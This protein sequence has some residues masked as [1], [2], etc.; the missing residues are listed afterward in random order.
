MDEVY[1][2]RTHEIEDDHWWYR[3]RRRVIEV[4]LRGLGLPPGVAILDAGCGSGRNMV[5]LAAFGSVTGLELADAS[6]A[7]ARGRGVGEVVQGTLEDMPFENARFDLAVSFDVIEHLDDDRRALGE[8]RRVVRPGGL[9]VVTVPAYQWL[10]S[11]H[12]VVN[13]HRRRYTRRTLEAAASAAGWETVS[14]THFNGLLLPAAVGHRALLRVRHRGDH[15]APP[16][17]DLE[18]TSPRLNRLLE[19]PLNLEARLIAAGRRIPCGLSL[20]AVFR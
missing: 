11:E 9:L 2:R 13:H 20:M 17:S 5:D 6:V 12:D 1:E 10:W 15:D 19:Q 18:R 3:G 7:R 8:L 4:A 16:V 14:T